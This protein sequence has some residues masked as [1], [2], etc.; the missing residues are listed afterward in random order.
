MEH[1]RRMASIVKPHFL[2]VRDY[3]MILLMT[4]CM[5]RESEA[6]AL[7]STDVTLDITGGAWCLVVLVQKSTLVTLSKA[8]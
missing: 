4:V 1:V 3:F 7:L 2:H 8:D 6:V 5:M